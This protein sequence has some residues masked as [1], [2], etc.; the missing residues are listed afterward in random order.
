MLTKSYY[1]DDRYQ[2]KRS[3]EN[4]NQYHGQKILAQVSLCPD[5]SSPKVNSFLSE[6]LI[7]KSMRK[8]LYK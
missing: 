1:L 6:G 8:K 5:L 7:L 2:F 3:Q 4:A